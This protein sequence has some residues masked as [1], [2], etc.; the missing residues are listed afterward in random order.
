MHFVGA[1]NT[2][3]PLNDVKLDLNVNVTFFLGI[4]SGNATNSFNFQFE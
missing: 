3:Y 4:L 2:E 1:P